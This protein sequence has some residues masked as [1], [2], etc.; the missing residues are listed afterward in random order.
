[1]LIGSINVGYRQKPYT[2]N[3]TRLALYAETVSG[4]IVRRDRNIKYQDIPISLAFLTDATKD[5][6]KEYLMDTVRPYGTAQIQG[7]DGL[8]IGHDPGAGPVS[9]VWFQDNFPAEWIAHNKWNVNLIFRKY[10]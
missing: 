2:D 6:L 9:L 7:D 4:G 10:Y 1:M 8:G 5:M 3:P